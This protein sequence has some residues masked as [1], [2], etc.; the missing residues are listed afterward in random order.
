MDM[1]IRFIADEG[2]IGKLRDQTESIEVLPI[3]HETYYLPPCYEN[4]VEQI[5][6]GV[7]RLRDVDGE[8]V[9]LSCNRRNYKHIGYEHEKYV[10]FIGSKS[11]VAYLI[12]A[13]GLKEIGHIEQKAQFIRPNGF[14]E[15]IHFLQAT[16]TSGY[17]SVT[18]LKIEAQTEEGLLQGLQLLGL[19]LNSLEQIDPITSLLT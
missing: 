18:T 2:L 5:A 9:E 6:F 16:S 1:S 7:I 3:A 17:S 4:A 11:K 12:S 13:L 10:L 8:T 19:D 14:D 15:N